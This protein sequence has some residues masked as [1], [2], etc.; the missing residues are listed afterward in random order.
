MILKA[1]GQRVSKKETWTTSPLPPK[2]QN[3]ARTSGIRRRPS[4]A[5]DVGAWT[6]SDQSRVSLVCISSNKDRNQ[7]W[8]TSTL[9]FNDASYLPLLVGNI[10][11]EVKLL[12]PEWATINS[13][14]A[15]LCGVYRDDDSLLVRAG[16]FGRRHHRPSR[17][18]AV[19]LGSGRKGKYFR[20]RHMRICDTE[21]EEF[22]DVNK[23]K[24]WRFVLTPKWMRRSVS[25]RAS[26]RVC[27]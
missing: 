24:M 26:C 18:T 7:L 3:G 27:P 6:C 12:T 9:I 20:S 19:Q 1:A 22:S 14:N 8:Q 13:L 21:S 17:T 23:K 11:P 25:F 5:D 4:C 10:K 16:V 15:S 2:T